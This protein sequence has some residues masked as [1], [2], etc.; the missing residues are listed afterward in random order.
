MSKELDETLTATNNAGAAID[1]HEF[2]LPRSAWNNQAAYFRM[3][4]KVKKYLDCF[5]QRI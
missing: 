1:E 2:V 3:L 5:E 4:F